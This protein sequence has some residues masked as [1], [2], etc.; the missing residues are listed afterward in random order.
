MFSK[1]TGC[2]VTSYFVS[3]P[4]LCTF[5]LKPCLN[6]SLPFTRVGMMVRTGR[7]A[8]HC[9]CTFLHGR[10]GCFCS[11]SLICSPRLGPAE[12]DSVVVPPAAGVHQELVQ[13]RRRRVH[14]VGWKRFSAPAPHP[15]LSWEFFL[16]DE[17][18]LTCLTSLLSALVLAF[19]LLHALLPFYQ[20]SLS[21]RCGPIQG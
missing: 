15:S 12:L 20:K 7:F 21:P 16:P 14:Q 10:S 13:L 19:L 11:F 9:L 6:V 18:L 1:D 5:S 2:L 8:P 4:Q 3:S 17:I